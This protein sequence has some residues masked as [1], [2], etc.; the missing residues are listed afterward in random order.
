VVEKSSSKTT[1]LDLNIS[2]Q[3][4]RIV[5]TTHQKDLNLYL[6]IPQVQHIPQD[7]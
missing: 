6:Y 5:T 4:S 7:A 3:N 2:I 1:F